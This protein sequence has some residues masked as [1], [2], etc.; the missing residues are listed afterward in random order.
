VP[1]GIARFIG[2]TPSHGISKIPEN[3]GAGDNTGNNENS[4]PD[5]IPTEF[6]Q[7]NAIPVISSAARAGLETG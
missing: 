4:L 6:V 7:Q 3:I 2:K 1:K 5:P